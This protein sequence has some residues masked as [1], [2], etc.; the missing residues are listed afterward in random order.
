MPSRLGP[1]GFS[2]GKLTL[3][4]VAFREL[5]Q[6]STL[7]Q[8]RYSYFGFGCQNLMTSLRSTLCFVR[9]DTNPEFLSIP[10]LVGSSDVRR[11]LD[12]RSPND[13][14][15]HTGTDSCPGARTSARTPRSSRWSRKPSR[16]RG[17]YRYG[18][19]FCPA[20]PLIFSHDPSLSA[21]VAE[22]AIFL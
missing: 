8:E 2:S 1:Y 22:A 18:D 5:L 14:P 7:D 20:L 15:N 6:R 3:V 4:L 9:T 19:G 12:H 10:E 13:A 11:T 17:R 16:L 21:D